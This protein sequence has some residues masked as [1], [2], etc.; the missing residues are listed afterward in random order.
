MRIAGSLKKGLKSTGSPCETRIKVVSTATHSNGVQDL[1][2]HGGQD[3]GDRFRSKD[4]VQCRVGLTAI[5]TSSAEGKADVLYSRCLALHAC[6]NP[7]QKGK[8]T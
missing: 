5:V 2:F 1:K 4:P 7:L 8:A 6:F 3:G